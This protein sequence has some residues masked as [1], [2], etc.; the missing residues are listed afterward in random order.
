MEYAKKIL[1]DHKD[2]LLKALSEWESKEYKEAYKIREDRLK[3]IN[4]VLELI[5]KSYVKRVENC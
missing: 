5:N 2:N 3:S 4:K 1:Q